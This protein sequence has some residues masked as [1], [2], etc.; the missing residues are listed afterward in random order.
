M[1][2]IPLT[3]S[4][5]TL[6]SGVFTPSF[7]YPSE[8]ITLLCSMISITSLAEEETLLDALTLNKIEAITRINKN[9]NT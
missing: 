5:N 3:I 8:R 1:L 7:M 2:A 4:T 9:N 6:S